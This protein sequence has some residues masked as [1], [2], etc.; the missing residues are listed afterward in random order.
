MHIYRPPRALIYKLIKRPSRPD[1]Q[2][3]K[4]TLSVQPGMNPLG[5]Y[6]FIYL[7]EGYGWGIFVNMIHCT[8]A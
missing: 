6:R 3:L 8:V 5:L 7:A 4:Q 1:L 2:G